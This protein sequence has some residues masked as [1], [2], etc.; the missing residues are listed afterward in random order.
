VRDD[1]IDELRWDALVD[2]TQITVEVAGGVVTLAGTVES[3]ARKL[4]AQEAAHAVAGVRDV[5]NAVD[6][7]P[8]AETCPSDETLEETV[9]QVLVWDALVPDREIAVRVSDGWVTLSGEVS[10]IAQRGEAERAIRHLAGVRGVSNEINVRRPELTPGNV[11]L[12][13]ETALRRRATHSAAHIDI[14][15][16]DGTVTLSGSTQTWGEKL[17]ILGAVGHAP[18][19]HTVCDELTIQQTS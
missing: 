2:E 14:T 6:V 17:A 7:R 4:A 13:I 15:V 18:G 3:Y 16:D 10:V 11:R 8:L 12:A 19:I 5:V 9:R 1:V